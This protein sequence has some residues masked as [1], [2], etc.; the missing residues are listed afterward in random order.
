[1]FLG[2]HSYKKMTKIR[3]IA[4]ILQ[5]FKESIEI[6]IDSRISH[7]NRCLNAVKCFELRKSYIAKSAYLQSGAQCHVKC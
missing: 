1:M 5:R 3:E 4:P 2:E 6:D 7:T